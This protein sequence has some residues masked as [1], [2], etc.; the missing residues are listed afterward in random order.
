MQVVGGRGAGEHTELGYVGW[1]VG[2][3]CDAQ[4]EE[5]DALVLG[6]S[7]SRE[8]VRV[9][10]VGDTI[11]EQNGHFDAS[12]AGLLQVDLGH[13]GDGVGGVSA[14]PNVDDGSYAGLEVLLASPVS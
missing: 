8:N 4:S 1:L 7:D 9:P 14:M 13:V 12:R 5:F 11:R 6:I 10:R 3:T 2:C